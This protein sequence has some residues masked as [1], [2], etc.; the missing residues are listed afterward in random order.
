MGSRHMKRYSTLLTIREMQTKAK[1][2]FLVVQWLRICQPVLRG[3]QFDSWSRKI[4]R[5]VGP[6]SLCSTTAEPKRCNY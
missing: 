1:G 3:T 6:L 5:A 4:P 2:T